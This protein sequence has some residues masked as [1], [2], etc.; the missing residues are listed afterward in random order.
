MDT[1]P[2]QYVDIPQ[3]AGLNWS[4]GATTTLT[5]TDILWRNGASGENAVWLMNGTNSAQY[6]AINQVTD[7]NWQIG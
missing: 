3:V 4:M 6:A 7:L 5:P 1:N 2:T